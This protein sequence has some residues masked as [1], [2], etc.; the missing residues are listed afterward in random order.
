M[1]RYKEIRDSFEW[2][3][4]WETFEGERDGR[5]NIGYEAV[6]RHAAGDK[7]DELAIRVVDFADETIEELNYGELDTAAG[8]LINYFHDLG[9][10]EGDRIATMVEPCG[11]LYAA[12]VGSWLGGFQL[13]PLSPLFG[14]DA[15]N[16]RMADAGVKA[17]VVSSRHRNKISPEEIASLEHVVIADGDSTPEKDI[18][19]RFGASADYESEYQV[20]ETH[21]DDTCTVQ[22]TSGTTGEPKGVL[23]K[24]SILISMYPGFTWAADHRPEHEY[25]GAGPPAWSYGLFGCTAFALATGMGTTAYR[26]EFDPDRFA[27]VLRQYDITNLFAPP[28]LLRQL[29]R[30]AID[31]ASLDASLELVATAGEPLDS[32]TIEWASDTLEAQIVD[33]Y[34]FTEGAMAINNYA[35]DDWTIKP[36][37]MGKPAPG[38]DVQILDQREDTPVPR[39]DVGEIAIRTENT[40]LN[41]DGYLNQPEKSTEKWSGEWLRSG[42]LGKLDEDGYV[43]FE[44]RAD[45]VILSAGHRIGPT[46]VE[47]TLMNHEAV[48]EAAV[49]GLPDEERGEIV[50]AFLV[51][52]DGYS[53]S[54]ELEAD[55]QQYVKTNLSK[56][57]YPRE[58]IFR[59]ELPKTNSG[60]IQRFKLRAQ[61]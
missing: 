3:Y 30:S 31:F 7:R 14:P 35:F 57:K 53:R 12:I 23:I 33:H 16:Y 13:V 6:G 28:T 8:R 59:E 22:Y 24:H 20:A 39:G 27:R 47:N 2:D 61:C 52:R 11:E 36:G 42:D 29:S 58:I 32:E 17:I 51:L 45:D 15:A 37:S 44:G 26:S 54:R 18:E 19:H 43:W 41:A 34:G 50:A 55:V 49:V 40:Y 1:G 56:T 10:T 4:V 5:F 9:L 38:F 25:F 48:A 46:E 21:A 60:K